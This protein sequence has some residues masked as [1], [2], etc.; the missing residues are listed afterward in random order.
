VRRYSMPNATIT[1]SSALLQQ[2]KAVA[3]ATSQSA[4]QCQPECESTLSS[5]LP[6]EDYLLPQKSHAALDTMKC[7]HANHRLHAAQTEAQ[8]WGTHRKQ[9][10]EDFE[11]E[12]AVLQLKWRVG[13]VKLGY[14]LSC[15]P[16][17]SSLTVSSATDADSLE[18][19]NPEPSRCAS[20]DRGILQP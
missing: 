13:L 17:F 16:R 5:T 10:V 1:A 14:D 7:L 3:V 19:P 2:P 20:V 15:D 4:V 12:A 9:R 18:E 8:R 11:L 6:L